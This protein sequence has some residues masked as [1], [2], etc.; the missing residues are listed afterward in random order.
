[1]EYETIQLQPFAALHMTSRHMSVSSLGCLSL[2]FNVQES[3]LLSLI[4]FSEP[5]SQR[6]HS[7]SVTP[8]EWQRGR[9]FMGRHA[10]CRRA[11]LSDYLS[12]SCPAVYPTSF[13]VCILKPKIPRTLINL[14]GLG[15]QL[16]NRR[17]N[18]PD[19][20]LHRGFSD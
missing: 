1:M 15:F 2:L 13:H 4:P 19:Y 12:L 20:F 17:A 8:I 11:N 18:S 10:E 16:D 6:T 14:H 9:N 5:S 7:I 3:K